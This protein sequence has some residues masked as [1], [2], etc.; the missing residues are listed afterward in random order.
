MG[1]ECRVVGAPSVGWLATPPIQITA[2][3]PP[4]RTAGGR[5]PGV[6]QVRLWSGHCV[7]D[8]GCVDWLRS[9][10]SLRNEWLALQVREWA[11]EWAATV[12]PQ[13]R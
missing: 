12:V 9:F 2:G 10:Y 11:W 13:V 7:T 6:C 1:E 8:V 5:L 3:G 4:I